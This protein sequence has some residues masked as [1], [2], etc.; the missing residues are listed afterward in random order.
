MLKINIDID[1]LVAE[2]EKLATFSDCPEPLPAVTRVVFT[3]TDRR[4]REYLR[5]LYEE[6]GL[7]VRVDAI[8]NT[9]ARWVGSDTSAP[10]VGTG[11]HCDAIPHAGMYDGTL[12]V[13]GGLEAIRSLQ[14]AGIEPRR[15]I[16]LVMFTS[17]EPTRFGMGCTG[18]RLLSGA[19]DPSTLAA[20]TDQA[21]TTFDDARQSA[22]FTGPLESVRLA[23]DYFSA[24]VELH[25]EQA[26]RLEE[27]T[28]PIGIVTAIAAPAAAEFVVVGQ[29]GHAGGVL[30]GDRHDALA[31]AAEM[32]IAIESLAK[33][34]SPDLV[35]TVGCVDVY[36]G[37]VNSIP[38]RVR[39]SLDLR[40]IDGPN[41]DKVLADITNATEQIASQRGV[42]LTRT[43]TNADPPA[44]ADKR[45]VA[46]V[47]KAAELLKLEATE[48]VSRAYH[49]SLFMARIAPTGMIFIPCR[50]GVSHRPDEYSS[51]EQ[52]E[53]GVSTLAMALAELAS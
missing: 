3:E 40:D 21:D 24:F 33:S 10:V 38:S 37:A 45:V 6:A 50:G 51:P 47:R 17:E 35:A 20:L 11:S 19:I 7:A 22:G 5:S 4:A 2:L 9:F 34:S 23:D 49:D 29:G 53:A 16:E 27:S 18:S 52:I 12:G 44:I 46:A 13:L 15:S 14:R 26:P 39:F 1:R 41:R 42:T 32:M 25:I 31:A 8:G 43:I 48:M 30:M 28:T 36:P